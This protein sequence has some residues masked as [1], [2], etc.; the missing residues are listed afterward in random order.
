M[1]YTLEKFPNTRQMC[2]I[3]SG[4]SQQVQLHSDVQLSITPA[5]MKSNLNSSRSRTKVRV[6]LEQLL[7]GRGRGLRRR[8]RIVQD[9][10]PCVGTEHVRK[11]R[12]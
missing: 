10:N 12:Q 3:L 1:L 7:E 6:Q 5:V 2:K 8:R 4:T 11:E 9:D